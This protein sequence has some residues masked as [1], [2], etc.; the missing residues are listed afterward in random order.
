[1]P[2]RAGKEHARP[3]Q[4]VISDEEP[5]VSTIGTTS[6]TELSAP[7]TSR[8][9][10]AHQDVAGSTSTQPSGAYDQSG[11]TT[12]SSP[13]LISGIYQDVLVDCNSLVERYRK[14]EI[15]KAAVYVDIQSKLF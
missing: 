9:H 6:A 11:F 3:T 7:S 14:G 12:G 4:P 10:V 8:T 5:R 15:S 1:M 13:E 2:P